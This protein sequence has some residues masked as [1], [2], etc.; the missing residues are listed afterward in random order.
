VLFQILSDHNVEKT[1]NTICA[2]ARSGREG[3]G[4]IFVY[5]V[6]E[7]VRIRTGEH[8]R[9]ALSYEGDIDQLTKAKKSR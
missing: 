9:K 7:V 6:E 2:A 4:M 8:G 1:I 3:D 5:P